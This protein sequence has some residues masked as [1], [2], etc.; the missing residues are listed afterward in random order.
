MADDDIKAAERRGYSKGYTAGK[1]RKEKL[2]TRE[3]IKA[4]QQQFIDRAFIAALPAAM[5]VQGWKRGEKPITSLEDRVQ[6]AADF[7][8]EAFRRRPLA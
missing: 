3:Q 2:I 6:L 8:R 1:R 4:Q 7:A 5:D